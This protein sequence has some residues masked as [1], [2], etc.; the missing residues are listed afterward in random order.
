[1]GVQLY[2]DFGA[3]ISLFLFILETLPLALIAF[4]LNPYGYPRRLCQTDSKRF[5]KSSYTFSAGYL[6]IQIRQNSRCFG[7]LSF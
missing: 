4:P 3:T 6:K 1:M 7:F 2:R 5:S